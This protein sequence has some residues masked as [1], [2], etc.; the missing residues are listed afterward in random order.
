M[1]AP[2]FALTRL[3]ALALLAG[4]SAPVASGVHDPLEGANRRVHAA[5]VALA[6]ALP[7]GGGARGPVAQELLVTASNVTGNLS[8]PGKVLN[9]V[10]Q[11]RPEPAVKN[12]F[13]FLINSTLGV[14]GLFDPA[15]TDFALP[16]TDT[17]FGETLH[18]WGVGEGPFVMLPV[19]GPSTARD[20]VGRV[21]DVVIDPS[22]GWFTSEQKWA[23]RG[24]R[25]ASKL[26]EAGQFSGTMDSILSDSADSY[27]QLR[28]IYLQKRRYEL[29][30]ASE[31]DFYDPYAEE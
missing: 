7:S 28:L 3:A 6:G 12:T 10:L 24:L 25:V 5:N 4:C 23:L 1:L 30:Q 14:A 19:L 18:V 8:L 21:V 16:E 29:G 31:D 2:R 22:D 13:R 17:D 20:T 26:G 27:A 15:G 11:G 9:S